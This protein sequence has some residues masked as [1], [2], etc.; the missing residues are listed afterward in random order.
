MVTSPN[1]VPDEI[2]IVLHFDEKKGFGFICPGTHVVED[3][4]FLRSAAGPL[5]RGDVVAFASQTTERGRKATRVKLL[6]PQL[7]EGD[8]HE[9]YE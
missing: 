4:L 8:D 2:G 3:V 6:R 9:R 1:S 7:A 5:H